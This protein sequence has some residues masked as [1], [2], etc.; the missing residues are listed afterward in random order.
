MRY[1]LEKTT[2]ELRDNSKEIEMLREER[3]KL[4]GMLNKYKE[5]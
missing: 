5:H 1:K 2:S 4:E 3:S